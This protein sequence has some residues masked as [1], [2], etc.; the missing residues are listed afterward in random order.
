MKTR[1]LMALLG[2]LALVACHGTGPHNHAHEEHDPAVE[3]HLHEHE[4][5][6]EHEAHGHEAEA[7]HGHAGEISLPAEKARA[8]G[9]VVDTVVRGSF[10]E[11]I[12]ASGRILPAPGD[13]KTVVASV[14]GVVSLPGTLTEGAQ[15]DE[16]SALLHVSSA[17][18]QD[19]D[20]VERARIAYE[21]ARAAYERAG[22]LVGDRIV[23]QKEF[24]A[25]R[26]D[27]ETARLAYEALGG[28]NGGGTAV[29][30]PM[31]GYVKRLLVGEGD[32]V[33]VGQPLL[34]LTQNRRLQLRADVPERCYPQLGS[35]TGANFRTA[36]GE[37]VYSTGE[38]G[39]RL[40]AYGRS[41]DD[42]AAYIP[43]TFAFDNRGDILPGSFAEVWLLAAPRQGVIS[44][45]VSALT[46]EQGV[47]FVYVQLDESCYRKQPVV[48][49]ATDGERVEI[50]EG[51]REGERV[52]MQGAV[53]VRLASASNAI[54]AHTH[55]H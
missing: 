26:A 52:V 8:A 15:V 31:R 20:P 5:P 17:H 12:V 44:L 4:T 13:E 2:S 41:S 35:L 38:L 48:T 40:V 29:R 34:T 49:G 21:T 1:T 30:S 3:T 25:A 39:G 37:K 43:V 54:P 6:E 42:A 22:K 28:S 11:V 14:P 46:E 36:S 18:L 10:R 33:T 47:Y 27:Y 50:V 19:G 53:H 51:L 45:P 24:E 55:N 9:V 32:Y 16:G 7:G 23:S